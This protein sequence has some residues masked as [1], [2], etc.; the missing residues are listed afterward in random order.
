MITYPFT[1]NVRQYWSNFNNV[2]ENIKAVFEILKYIPT[3]KQGSLILNLGNSLNE[4]ELYFNHQALPF[5]LMT[6]I[7]ELG[8]NLTV[9]NIDPTFDFIEIVKQF[10]DVL[11]TFTIIDTPFK[12]ILHINK[13]INGYDLDLIFSKSSLPS[14]DYKGWEAINHFLESSKIQ[15]DI[16]DQVDKYKPNESD[17]RFIEDYY[18]T[19]SILIKKNLDIRKKVVVIN[20][21]IFSNQP[22]KGTYFGMFNELLDMLYIHKDVRIFEYTSFKVNTYEYSCI[23]LKRLKSNGKFKATNIYLQTGFIDKYDENK[24]NIN[25]LISEKGNLEIDYI[26]NQGLKESFNLTYF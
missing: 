22:W 20:Y 17:R 8:E 21:C 18:E 14:Y 11:K 4:H 26:N 6:Y 2:E 9:L 15:N 23:E 3:I 24:I 16:K 5:S 7:E 19:F 13:K 25:L 1:F 12:S 10:R